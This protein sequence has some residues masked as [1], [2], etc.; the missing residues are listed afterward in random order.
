MNFNL[1]VLRPDLQESFHDVEIVDVMCA[2]S[3]VGE[4]LRCIRK[5]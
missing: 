5:R 4:A 3:I 1:L 2:R